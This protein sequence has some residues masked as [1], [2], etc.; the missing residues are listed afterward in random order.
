MKSTGTVN[1]WIDRP[2]GDGEGRIQDDQ[3]GSEPLVVVFQSDV[4]GGGS[5]A[6]GSRVSYMRELDAASNLLIARNVAPA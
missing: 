2:G 4:A 6:V 5:L 1:S 3:L